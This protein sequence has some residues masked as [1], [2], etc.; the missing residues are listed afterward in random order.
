MRQLFN[1]KSACVFLI[2]ATI[3]LFGGLAWGAS[4]PPEGVDSFPRS[5]ESYN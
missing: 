1:L 5:L 4:P 3:F 2:P